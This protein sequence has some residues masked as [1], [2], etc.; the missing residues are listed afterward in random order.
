MIQLFKFGENMS[1]CDDVKKDNLFLGIFIVL[2]FGLA[3]RIILPSSLAMFASIWMWV[4]LAVLVLD[5]EL[6]EFITKAKH[7]SIEY[8]F[9]ACLNSFLW[10]K[11]I[12][13]LLRDRW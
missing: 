8:W 6:P 11:R 2:I 12:G 1:S 13:G 10:P 4:G 5:K 3:L 7:S 9:R